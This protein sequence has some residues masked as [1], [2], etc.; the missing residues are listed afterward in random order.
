MRLRPS[1]SFMASLFTLLV[2][3]N[4]IGP[5]QATGLV[6]PE[7]AACYPGEQGEARERILDAASRCFERIG[8]PKTTLVDLATP[9]SRISGEEEM[10]ELLRRLLPPTA[11]ANPSI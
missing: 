5:E 8:V 4:P 9:S 7:K 11:M 3:L 6:S 2:V 1:T 10:R